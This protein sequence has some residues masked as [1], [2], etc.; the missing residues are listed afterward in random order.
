MTW[1]SLLEITFWI[2][3]LSAS[4]RVA[5]PLIFA[6]LGESVCE[7]AGILNV[8]VEGMMALGAIAGFLAAF[9]TG[10]PWIGFGVAIAVGALAGLLFGFL[11]VIRGADQ[12]VTGVVF[13]IFALGLASFV[14]ARL[15]VSAHSV[16]QLPSIPV[17]RVPTLSTLPFVGKPFFA[18]TPIVYCAYAL[19]PVFW[20]LLER[21][22]WGLSARAAG[23]NPEAVDSAGLDVWRIRLQATAIGGAMA[24]LAGA[25]LSIAQVGA[26]VDGMVAG[27]GF[28]AL[29]IVVFGAWRPWGVALAALLFGAVDAL[30]L[31]MQI[32]GSIV[33]GPLLVGLPYL[34]TIVV[35]TL[36]AARAGYPA[37][38]NKPYARRRL[39]RSRRV[40]TANALPAGTRS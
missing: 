6:G 14:Y 37:A 33:P 32:G 20:F 8:G 34:L 10:N 3:L 29:A 31:R 1:A 39:S 26:Y 2:P 17:Y 27:R 13:N 16:A 19:V 7:R 4:I 12:I 5:T 15:F 11:T 40:A 18:Q 9:W 35:V 21:S 28:I 38:I 25:T 36:A 22:P 23:E 24:G 30:Q